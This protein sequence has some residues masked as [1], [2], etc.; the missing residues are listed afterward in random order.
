M[1][2]FQHYREKNRG[3]VALE[4]F[5]AL[6]SNPDMTMGELSTALL[7]EDVKDFLNATLGSVLPSSRRTTRSNRTDD[8][9]VKDKVLSVLRSNPRE[10]FTVQD[11]QI[12]TGASGGRIRQVLSDFIDDDDM[13]VFSRPREGDNK[14]IRPLEYLWFPQPVETETTNE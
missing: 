4:Y 2:T 5:R 8:I 9:L 1:T 14:G 7:D 12:D 6:L 3:L 13:L 11:L 10:G